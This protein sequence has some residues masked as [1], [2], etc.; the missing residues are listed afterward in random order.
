M[1]IEIEEIR[2]QIGV[3]VERIADLAL[4]DLR[5]TIDAGEDKTSSNEKQLTHVTQQD[6]SGRCW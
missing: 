4:K 5:D 3:L 2:S 1:S 6:S